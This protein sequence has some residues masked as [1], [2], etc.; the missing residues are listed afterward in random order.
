[1]VVSLSGITMNDSNATKQ[2]WSMDDSFASRFCE[3]EAIKNDV[4]D[5]EFKFVPLTIR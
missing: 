3:S 1:M 2:A 4:L 5:G